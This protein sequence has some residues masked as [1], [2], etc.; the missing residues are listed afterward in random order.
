LRLDWFGLALGLERDHEKIDIRT[1]APQVLQLPS[2]PGEV[3]LWSLLAATEADDPTMHLG[4]MM[5]T[6]LAVEDPSSTILLSGATDSEIEP[7]VWP[8]LPHRVHATADFPIVVRAAGFYTVRC[9]IELLDNGDSVD[10]SAQI[11]LTD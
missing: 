4:G 7:K 2:L 11:Y 3:A 5:R 10:G 6:S 1:F 8:D 9:S